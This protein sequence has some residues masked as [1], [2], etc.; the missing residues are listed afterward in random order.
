[1][2]QRQEESPVTELPDLAN[3]LLQQ[4]PPEFWNECLE[5]EIIHLPGT[6]IS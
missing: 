4:R 6:P 3:P 5:A 1:M 2:M